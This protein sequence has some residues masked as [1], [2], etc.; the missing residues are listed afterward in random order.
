[1]FHSVIYASVDMLR[2]CC[3]VMCFELL[4]KNEKGLVNDYPTAV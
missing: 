2:T 1:M 3:S 4:L